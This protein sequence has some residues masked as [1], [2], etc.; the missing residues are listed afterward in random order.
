M[1]LT[2]AG[3]PRFLIHT[4]ECATFV[5]IELRQISLPVSAYIYFNPSANR[6]L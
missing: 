3:Q 1:D 6:S 2:D 4:T 5:L